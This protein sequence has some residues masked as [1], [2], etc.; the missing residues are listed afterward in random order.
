MASLGTMVFLARVILLLV[1]VCMAV[2]YAAATSRAVSTC[3]WE[4]LN[5]TLQGRLQPVRPLALPC[6]SSYGNQTVEPDAAAC[7]SV[8]A[9]YTS[10]AFRAGIPGAYMNNQVE[11][12]ASDPADQCLLDNKQPTDA[13]A[14]AN[15]TCAQGDLPS[16]FVEV[17]DPSDVRA[18][19]KFSNKTGVPLVIKNSGHDYLARSSGK[20][21]LM[22]WTR[23][24]R[25]LTYHADFV[26]DGCSADPVQA[27]TTGAGVNFGEAYA[28]ADANNVTILGGYSST[29]GASG[30]WAL[31]GGHSI[32][33][34]VYGLGIDRT[35]QFK[36]VTPDGQL[37][38]VNACRD[39]DL[40]W[41]LKGGGGGTFGVVMETTHK[42][43]PI[44]SFVAAS[45]S[46]TSNKTTIIPFLDIIVNNTLK[47]ASEGWGGHVSGSSLINITPL[48]SLEEAQESLASLTAYAQSQGGSASIVQYNSWYPFYQK[49]V[50]ANEVAVGNTH[51]A[52]SQLVPQSAFADEAGRAEI[53]SF[54]S[55]LVSKGTSPYIPVVGPV[56]YNATA[57]STSATPAW[58]TAVWELGVGSTWAW[59]STLAERQAAATALKADDARMANF[60]G[61]SAYSNEASIFTDNWEEAWWGE[62]YTPLLAIKNKYDPHGILGCYKCVG[63][64]PS[65]AI[66]S[67]FA[68]FA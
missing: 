41:A 26:A 33:S 16:Y 50:V 43:E 68:A 4:Q 2:P 25:N 15:T 46:F 32:L 36:I 53:M 17:R 34:P 56:L 61:G 5:A 47:W 45:V 19:F 28:F 31:G 49:Y 64:A 52:G 29:V 58:R 24:I 42:V 37:R 38:T 14:F 3:A 48:L 35:L 20:G 9:N 65:S 23:N 10:A 22:L 40:F 57:N 39:P 54:L 12:C 62:N 7:A 6:F 11:E 63:W 18:A 55:G 21:A 8:Q 13:L 51:L 44:I 1:P 59:N 60:T 30:G 67:C 66:G 27:I